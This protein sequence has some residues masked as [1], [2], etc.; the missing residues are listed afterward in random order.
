MEK[1]EKK[2]R[3]E[4]SQG[5]PGWGEIGESVEEGRREIPDSYM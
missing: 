5:R 1:D 3:E 4:K 2:E